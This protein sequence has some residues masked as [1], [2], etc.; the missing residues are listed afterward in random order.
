MRVA[1]IFQRVF[2]G[3]YGK[4]CWNV[5]PGY[6]SF[7]TFEFG[8]PHL[9]IRAPVVASEGSSRR[10]REL[11]SRRNVFVHGEWHLR[12][13]CCAWEVSSNGKHIANGSTRLGVKRG[14]KFLD[15]QKLVSFSVEPRKVRCTFEF[16]LGVLKTEAYDKTGEQWV[17]YT[18][19]HRALTLRADQRYQYMHSDLPR[20]RSAW[21]AAFA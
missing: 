8:K 6:G 4:P 1:P 13:Y 7:L 16:D 20:D 19:D 10:V 15:G 2:L 12:I 11:L 21:K 9:Q 18:P 14:A 5:K 3:V 17:L